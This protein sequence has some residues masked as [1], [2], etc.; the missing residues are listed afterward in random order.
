MGHRVEI[1]LDLCTQW[2]VVNLPKYGALNQDTVGVVA[3]RELEA[4][5]TV[6]FASG[7][8]IVYRYNVDSLSGLLVVVSKNQHTGSARIG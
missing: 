3:I 2:S 7:F 4:Q 8:A 1:G 5:G 6:R